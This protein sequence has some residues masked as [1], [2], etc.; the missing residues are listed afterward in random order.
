MNCPAVGNGGNRPVS[1]QTIGRIKYPEHPTVI[2]WS[3]K[4]CVTVTQSLQKTKRI[5]ADA[6]TC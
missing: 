1:A 5:S 4:L 3:C 6:E 2:I